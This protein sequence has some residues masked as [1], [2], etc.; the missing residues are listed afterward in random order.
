[1]HMGF[2]KHSNNWILHFITSHQKVK[3]WGTIAM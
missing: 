1:M 2:A 3:T